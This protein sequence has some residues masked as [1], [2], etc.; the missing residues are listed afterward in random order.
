MA[1]EGREEGRVLQAEGTAYVKAQRQKSGGI[2][3]CS[4]QM[5]GKLAG[6]EETREQELAHALG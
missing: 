1:G 6:N 5:L 2:R 3:S 4:L